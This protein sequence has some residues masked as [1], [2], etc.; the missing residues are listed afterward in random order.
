M[1]TFGENLKKL[2]EKAGLTQS[3][4]ASMCFVSSQMIC[5]IEGGSKQ[6]SLNLAL[7]LAQV[8]GTDVE[9]IAGKKR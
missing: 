4:L 9:T 3:E 5:C 7:G 1:S 2:R 6:P 8:L